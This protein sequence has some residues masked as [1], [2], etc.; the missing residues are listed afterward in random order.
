MCRNPKILVFLASGIKEQVK[1]KWTCRPTVISHLII[2]LI[3]VLER[4]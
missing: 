1:Q 4:N 2:L 3:A